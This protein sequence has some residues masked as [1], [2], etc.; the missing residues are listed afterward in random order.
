MTHNKQ[1]KPVA[2]V[3]LAGVLVLC[4][5]SWLAVWQTC[6]TLEPIQQAGPVKDSIISGISYAQKLA[7]TIMLVVA[8][9]CLICYLKKK[10]MIVIVLAIVMGLAWRIYLALPR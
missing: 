5:V 7:G 6:Y 10:Y 9:F 1:L 8:A 4:L 3:S 2:L